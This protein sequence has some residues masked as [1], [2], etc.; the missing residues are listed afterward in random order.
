[1]PKEKAAA[2]KA[3]ELDATLARPHAT[4][5]AIKSQYNWD[6]SGAEAEFRKALELDASDATAHQWYS[7]HLESI[8]GRVSGSINE[9]NPPHELD[10][11][12]PTT[13]FAQAPAYSYAR[14]FD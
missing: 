12:S 2:E 13:G 14:Q 1:M 6:F 11:P 3:L 5:G 9:S 7:Q 4:L 8:G 10:P